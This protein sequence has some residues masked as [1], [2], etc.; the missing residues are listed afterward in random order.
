MQVFSNEEAREIIDNNPTFAKQYDICFAFLILYM[1][2]TTW[3]K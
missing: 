3:L 2:E 1:G